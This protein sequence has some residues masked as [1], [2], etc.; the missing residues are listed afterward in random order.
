MSCVTI[1]PSFHRIIIII[2]ELYII[3]CL[4]NYAHA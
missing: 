1:I 3:F 2:R 4:S